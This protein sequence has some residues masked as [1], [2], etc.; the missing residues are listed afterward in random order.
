MEGISE[1]S[2]FLRRK[3][4]GKLSEVILRTYL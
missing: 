2:C 4:E 1:R 3:G